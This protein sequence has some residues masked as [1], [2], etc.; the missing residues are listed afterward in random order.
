MY[1]NTFAFRN[2]F[3]LIFKNIMHYIIIT[4]NIFLD[5]NN[6]ENYFQPFLDL[7]EF[8]QNKLYCFEE[9]EKLKKNL[10]NLLVFI[11]ITL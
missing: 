11:I 6:K 9:L 1:I 5:I 8:I 7:I 4:V 2:I 10:R 3:V